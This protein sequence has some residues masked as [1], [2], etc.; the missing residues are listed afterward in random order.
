MGYQI[1]SLANLP[2][3]SDIDL[4]VFVLGDWGP[5]LRIIERRF[6]QISKQLGPRAALILGPEGPELASELEHVAALS[7][8]V[9]Q[10]I[11]LGSNR[12]PGLLVLGAHPREFGDEDLVLYCPAEAIAGDEHS[13]VSFFEQIANFAKTADPEFL[14]AFQEKHGSVHETIA[15]IRA[16]R[17]LLGI[18]VN[19]AGTFKRLSGR[20]SMLG[21]TSQQETADPVAPSTI[22]EAEQ[23]SVT[24][25]LR[26]RYAASRYLGGGGMGEVYLGRDLQNR[27]RLV[28]IKFLR[29]HRFTDSG[30]RLFE[31]E[32]G[33]LLGL[34]Q[35][36][37]VVRVYDSD[38]RN[39]DRPYLVTEYVNGWNLKRFMS[40]ENVSLVERL[41]LFVG[42][43]YTLDLIH[44]GGVL[45][46][47][48][49]PENILI[50]RKRLGGRLQHVIC[51]F[52]LAYDP[53]V[54]SGEEDIRGGT[55]AYMSPE[56]LDGKQRMT[57]QS[58]I[59]SL[60][61]LLSWL[62]TGSL[63]HEITLVQ[64]LDTES[65]PHQ[66]PPGTV[67]DNVKTEI[68]NGFVYRGKMLDVVQRAVQP[69]PED[70]FSSAGE[71]GEAV[72]ELMESKV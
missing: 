17:S 51:D 13:L 64:N 8:I 58:D 39:H 66:A 2:T 35:V 44:E 48:I 62:T 63:P 67:G 52:G 60:G 9:Q 61:V 4:Y 3:G 1:S 24:P 72:E 68:D 31:R 21:S 23:P 46:R 32:L 6:S 70:R 28:A 65:S 45:H 20:G 42:L 19:L 41:N 26:G 56:H 55:L 29:R 7:E 15:N 34:D 71:L 37:G 53:T 47:D 43:C 11:S 12:F 5:A 22:S 57:P 38:L 25:I 40:L 14:N 16:D 27:D 33:V 59:Y 18:G 69:R 36:P 30:L 54:C 49:K 50:R 10:F